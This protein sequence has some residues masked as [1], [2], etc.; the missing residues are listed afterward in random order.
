M[1][2]KQGKL[3]K[4]IRQQKLS[5]LEELGI[6]SCEMCGSSWL[7]DLA[8]S[9]KRRKIENEEELGEVALL[10]RKCH[11]FIEYKLPQPEMERVVKEIIARRCQ[12][13]ILEIDA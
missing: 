8:H 12:T 4:K 11:D 13:D 10:C 5:E 2:D 9:K 3:W 6:G 1:R 7:L